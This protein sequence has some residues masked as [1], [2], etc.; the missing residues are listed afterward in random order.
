M[1]LGSARQVLDPE[2]GVQRAT[3]FRKS[4]DIIVAFLEM[5]L[6]FGATM[7]IEA[8]VRSLSPGS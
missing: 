5:K 1:W 7:V 3:V 2:F 8:P 6:D 4:P